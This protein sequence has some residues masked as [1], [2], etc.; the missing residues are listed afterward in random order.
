MKNCLGLITLSLWERKLIKHLAGFRQNTDPQSTDSLLTPLLTPHKINGKMKIF[1]RLTNQNF[2]AASN[3]R[4][5]PIGVFIA[6]ILFPPSLILHFIT[7]ILFLLPYPSPFYAC[8]AGYEPVQCLYKTF[9]PY[10]LPSHLKYYS[11]SQNFWPFKNG[12][13]K[14]FVMMTSIVCLSSNRS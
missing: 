2:A 3:C 8:Y 5:E 4:N 12:R 10:L 7:R 13:G 6:G 14:N 9:V 1:V 11:N